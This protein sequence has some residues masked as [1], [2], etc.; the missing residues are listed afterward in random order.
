MTRLSVLFALLAAA[1]ASLTLASGAAAGNA[2]RTCKI[3][4]PLCT[5]VSE[6]IN[7]IAGGPYVGHDEPSLLFYSNRKG[8]GNDVTYDIRLPKDPPTMP[9]QDSANGVYWGFEQRAAY[10]FGMIMCDTQSAPEFQHRTCKPDSDSNIFDSTDPSSS[11]YIGKAPGN[12]YM[13]CS[14]TSPAG[15]RSSPASAAW[16]PSGASP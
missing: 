11:R 10:W 7:D 1:A 4:I 13:E 6:P 9:T 5:D 8:S 15:C 14:S 2:S 3:G 16:G 12:A